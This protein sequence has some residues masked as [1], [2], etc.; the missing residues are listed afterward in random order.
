MSETE[1]VEQVERPEWLPENFESPEALA[2]SYA[3]AQRAL[4][5]RGEADKQR[6]AELAELR[7]RAAQADQYETYLQQQ[8]DARRQGDPR[9]RVLEIIEDP[10]RH[11]DL[12]IQMAQQ[13]ADLQRRLEELSQRGP[14]QDVIEIKAAEA[15]RIIRANNTDYDDHIDS[16]R[17]IVQATPA[18]V[19]L[20]ESGTPRQI[21]EGL[22]IALDAARGRS[23]ASGHGQAANDAATAARLAREQAQ[24]MS[25][26]SSRPATQTADEEYWDRVKAA[27]SGGY[28]S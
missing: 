24:T 1:Q 26:G 21:A 7:A 28:G 4:S 5:A 9:E 27:T 12:V 19:S 6:E 3:E 13:Q 25:G 23:L 14:D 2:A 11:A 20:T 22:Q 8:E 16:I 18:L 10:D 17:E 15:E